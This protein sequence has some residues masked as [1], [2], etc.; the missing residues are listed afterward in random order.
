MTRGLRVVAFTVLAL[1]AFAG[2]S[3]LARAAIGPAADG[4][5]ALDPVGFTALRLAAGA[6]VLALL[7]GPRALALPAS[8]P[9]RRR[10]LWAVVALVAYALPFSVAYVDLGAA[11]GA[12]LLFGAVQVTM[13]AVGVAAGERTGARGLVGWLAALAGLVVLLLPGAAAPDPLAAI[14]MGAGGVAW[15]V[16]SLLGR[17]ERAPLTATAR[18]F[19]WALP[20][21]LL[22][23][24]WPGAWAGATPAGAGLAVASGALTSGLG[25]AVWYAALP[26]LTRTVAAVV[27]L[28]VPILAAVAAV[29]WLG[30]GVGW[31]FGLA[32]LLVL[33]GIAAVVVPA[34]PA[35]PRAAASPP[36]A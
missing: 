14:V 22:L 25:Y 12:L 19:V 18:A 29:A 27:Q 28:A 8:R 33:G 34:K 20:A 23:A 2:N 5:A 7:V 30:E 3:L 24:A 36:G 16:Y 31:R 11:T 6:A 1:L 17:A 35:S 9:A 13:G 15:G 21:A 4:S 26:A 32:S 10:V